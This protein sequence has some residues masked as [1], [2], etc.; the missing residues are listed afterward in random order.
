MEIPKEIQKIVRKKGYKD[1][2]DYLLKNWNKIPKESQD[3]LIK[4]GFNPN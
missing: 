1:L 4:K 2:D 3:R